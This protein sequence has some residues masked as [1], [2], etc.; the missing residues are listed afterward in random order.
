M[1]TDAW[2]MGDQPLDATVVE[3]VA[4]GASVVLGGT[5]RERMNTSA[6]WYEAH[7]PHDVLR[8]KWKWLVGGAAPTAP[9]EAV[10]AFVESHCAGVGP[11]LTSEEV[12][13]LMVVRAHVLSL[14]W[15]GVRPAVVERLLA[16]LR[17]GW[18]PVVPR[19]GSVGA[20]GCTALAHVARVVLGFGGEV[21][22]AEDDSP[23]SAAGLGLSA[24][25]INEKEALALINGS[26]LATGLAALAVARAQRLLTAAEAACALTMEAV[27]AN[28]CALDA[29]AARTRGH[30]GIQASAAR[31]RALVTGSQLVT[32][33]RHPD[34]F[35]VR[36][37]P[38]VSGAARSALAHVRGVVEDELNGAGDNP[39]VV[40]G[41]PGVV[42]AGHFHG[43]PV[44]LAMD[45]LKVALAQ[46]AGIAERRV[47]RLT[48]GELSGLPS[49]LVPGSGLNSG[50]M[51]AQYTAASLVSEAKMLAFP[52]SADSIPTVQHQE[53]H[54]PMGPSAARSA[55]EVADRVADVIAIELMCAAQ[56]LEFREPEHAQPGVGTQGVYETVRAYVSR[57]TDDRVLH[58]DLEALGGAVRGGAFDAY[59]DP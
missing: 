37:A 57:L 41:H 15:S 45:Y 54:V 35:S 36:C 23:R 16:F 14:G 55:L 52:G 38:S 24:L 32:D 43:A 26:S 59:G 40:P 10:R 33:R 11:P 18:S 27:R 29:T 25:A 49:F 21:V 30:A 3:R 20:A 1:A 6:E 13:A 5:A 2:V 44:A 53:D 22:T 28:L 8:S 39:L 58:P 17:Q 31:L 42:E 46:L 7:G 48:Y 56:A 51:L 50:L 4:Q 47:F 9:G 19:Q 12:R 34:S